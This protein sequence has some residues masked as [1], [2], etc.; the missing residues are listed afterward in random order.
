[1]GNKRGNVEKLS[2]DLFSIT[3]F[4]HTEK[5]AISLEV[6]GICFRLLK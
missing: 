6:V 4:V 1:M 2:W 5:K 3:N